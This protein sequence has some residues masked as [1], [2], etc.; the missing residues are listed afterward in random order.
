MSSR[1]QPI[2]A[3]AVAAALVGVACVT[4]SALPRAGLLVKRRP[5]EVQRAI[6]SF[7]LD[8][9]L[10]VAL[11]PDARTN[12]VS[13]DV[14]YM[15]GSL[16]DLPGRSGLAHLAE[17]LSFGIA[18]HG[19]ATVAQRLEE[20]AL[21]YSASTT[22]DETH[23]AS[24]AL[25][26]RLGDV[27][28]IEADR[29]AAPCDRIAPEV[30]ER[31]R[32]VVDNELRGRDT[33]GAWAPL[34]ARLF[35]RDH[36]YGR[37]VSG[38]ELGAIRLADVCGFLAGHYAPA[39]AILV[40]G[41]AID[42]EAARALVTSRFGG[43]RRVSSPA[44]ALQVVSTSG[45]SRLAS[46]VDQPTAVIAFPASP[47]GLPGQAT[48]DLAI[49]LW[50]RRILQLGWEAGVTDVERGFLGGSRGGVELIAITARDASALPRA[51]ELAFGA[52]D[53]LFAGEFALDRRDVRALR[54]NDGLAAL[55]RFEGLGARVA[56]AIQH[57]GSVDALLAPVRE[58]EELWP[59]QLVREVHDIGMV[60]VER[61]VDLS[62]GSTAMVRAVD[63]LPARGRAHVAYL[64]PGAAGARQGPPDGARRIDVAE[65]QTPVDVGE[66]ERPLVVAAGRRAPQLRDV[67]LADGLRVVLAPVPG[68][69][70][71]DARLVFPAGL[72]HEPPDKS[73]VALLA[74]LLLEHDLARDYSES[75]RLRA[76][77][78]LG[79]GGKV[80]FEIGAASTV[81]R[82]SGAARDADWHVWRLLWLI[83]QGIYTDW[84]LARVR[85]AV[86]AAPDDR[87]RRLRRALA[88]ALLGGVTIREQDAD[89]PGRIGR[90]AIEAFRRR[91]YVPGGATLIVVGGFD[92]DRILA[93]IQE[94]AAAWRGKATATRPRAVT[95]VPHGQHYLALVDDE[96]PQVSIA[97]AFPAAGGTSAARLVA[98]EMVDARARS[99]RHDIGATYGL[100]A[101]Y[102]ILASAAPALMV[103]GDADPARAGDVLAAI[104]R[105]LD[106]LR[107]DGDPFRRAFVAARRRVLGRVLAQVA[108]TAALAAEL[109]TQARVGWTGRQR[110]DL[111]A[112]VA[113]L[114]PAAVAAALSADLDRDRMVVALAGPRA[115][116]DAAFRASRLQGVQQVR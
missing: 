77:W 91:S 83:E 60:K 32:D 35:P 38:V 37:P 4:S 87:E 65:W 101:G 109:E 12:L 116:I 82:L 95:L 57:G 75:D 88:G 8:S 2:I 80:T 68:S 103:S 93:E 78:A 64:L 43:I 105:S 62:A 102:T 73:G 115:A 31:E 66:A 15:T 29:M 25:A 48:R 96:S 81:F 1:V 63:S 69:V 11:V 50:V 72:A 42:V 114:T 26:P 112:D 22:W 33:R 21:V 113:T 28:A 54:I 16:D 5:L 58:L 18:E 49:D 108:D 51:V 76:S 34:A 45:E 41:G 40:L 20:A 104:L 89:A 6:V 27:L 100:R 74:A 10:R 86:A 19:G 55:D 98:A 17:H 70:V 61:Y 106:E 99:I 36:P 110:K 94:L 59:D 71:V 79:L 52:R 14:R 24:L 13:V 30:L 7:R 97:L 84:S 46:A 92:A 85:D 3:G 111:V 56:D 39:R 9:G 107:A 44:R 53:R 67:V 90:S 47:R 23:F